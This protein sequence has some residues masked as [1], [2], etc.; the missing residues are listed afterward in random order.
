MPRDAEATIARQKRERFLP[1]TEA[2]KAKSASAAVPDEAR[3]S[4]A[5]D[6]REAAAGGAVVFLDD[7]AQCVAGVDEVHEG[8]LEGVRVDV[9][10]DRFHRIGEGLDPE[11]PEHFPG[12]PPR[13]RIVAEV[14]AALAA[15][16]E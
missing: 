9:A 4:P 2:R 10:M 8:A 16:E 11:Q 12:M 13:S 14:R 6:R 7:G 15:A 1:G 5:G 3:R